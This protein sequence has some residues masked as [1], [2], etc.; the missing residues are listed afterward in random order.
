[1]MEICKCKTKQTGLFGGG[2]EPVQRIYQ[3]ITT[4]KFCLIFLYLVCWNSKS[5]W[6]PVDISSHAMTPA[7]PYPRP[8]LTPAEGGYMA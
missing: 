3:H 7:V 4:N 6:L 2:R 8:A 5:K 1:M